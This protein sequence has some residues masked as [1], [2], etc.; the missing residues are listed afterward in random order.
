MYL[1]IYPII[2][3]NN[4]GLS[5][6]RETATRVSS[7]CATPTPIRTRATPWGSARRSPTAGSSGWRRAEMGRTGSASATTTGDRW[8][9]GSASSPG[10]D[11]QS[12]RGLSVDSADVST[13][14]F[15][16]EIS[17]EWSRERFEGQCLLLYPQ[18]PRREDDVWRSDW[19]SVSSLRKVWHAPNCKYVEGS[20]GKSQSE[21]L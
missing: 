13:S 4:W 18:G 7:T 11:T 19:S 16:D 5:L 1:N 2:H 15:F 12:L 3:H 8:P 20:K 14:R 10:E 17:L 9:G 6:R 21:A